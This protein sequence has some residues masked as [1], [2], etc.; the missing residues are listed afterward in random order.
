M[1]AISQREE[2]MFD[3]AR[4]IADLT[5]RAPSHPEFTWVQS[6]THALAAGAAPRLDD[7]WIAEGFRDRSGVLIGA[8]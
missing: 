7:D 3:A 4:K 8:Q 2:D 6:Q 5:A 1:N